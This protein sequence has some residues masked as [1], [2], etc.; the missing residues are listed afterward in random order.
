M[1]AGRMAEKLKERVVDKRAVGKGRSNGAARKD[2]KPHAGRDSKANV[3][4]DES[5]ILDR[6][7]KVMGTRVK[8]C[9]GW[10]H[11]CELS[12]TQ[13]RS[14]CSTTRRAVSRLS[15][16]LRSWSTAS[17]DLLLSIVLRPLSRRQREGR[18]HRRRSMESSWRGSY[19]CGG[20]AFVGGP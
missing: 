9:G 12:V 4:R 16:S 1:Q 8:L 7:I 2:V 15:L 19:L 18:G 17:C 6:A 14:R 13:R 3:G 11:R 10:E 20:N 5:A